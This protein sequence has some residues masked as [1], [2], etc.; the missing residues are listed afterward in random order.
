MTS[1]DAIQIPFDNLYGEIGAIVGEQLRK[2]TISGVDFEEE[3]FNLFSRGVRNGF[4]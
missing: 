4:G 3:V 1:S 2:G